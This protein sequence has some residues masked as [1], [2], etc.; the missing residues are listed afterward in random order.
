MTEDTVRTDV[1]ARGVA[2]VRLSRPEVHNAYNSEMIAGLA[3]AVEAAASDP[4]VRVVVLRGEGKHFQA[5][6][7]LRWVRAN[8][9]LTQEENLAISRGTTEA[10][11]RLNELPKPTVALVHGGCF[12]GG[13]GMVAACDVVI[14]SEDAI[15]AITETR[16]GLVP[17]PILPQL[18]AR[19]GLKN[20]RRYALSS[21]RFGAARAREVGLVDEVCA[22]GGLD[23][24]AAP[25]ID[26]FLMA[27]PQ[28]IAGTKALALE[29]GAALVDAGLSDRLS[30]FHART[31]TGA[32]AT[33]G[34]DSFLEKRKPAWYPGGR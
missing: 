21:E 28:A 9:D 6:A 2:T 18:V 3:A 22:Q 16:W 29:L 13:T 24:A 26:A 7:D 33:E 32:E 19:M 17:T 20:V 31:R 1:D 15:F 11:R 25:V 34:L 4:K 30:H 27:G 8:Q 10:V 23:D 14:A 12:G 5:G